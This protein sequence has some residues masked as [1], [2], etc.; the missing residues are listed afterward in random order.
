MTVE[1]SR[2]PRLREGKRLQ[3]QVQIVYQITGYDQNWTECPANRICFAPFRLSAAA[4]STDDIQRQAW[5]PHERE[6][7]GE[8]REG[9]GREG[10]RERAREREMGGREGREGGRVAGREGGRE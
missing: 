3:A 8:G 9:G 10:A 4:G 2:T 6:R 7:E 1:A 5:V